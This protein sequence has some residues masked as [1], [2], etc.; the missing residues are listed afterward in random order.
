MKYSY[1]ELWR[2]FETAILDT[3]LDDTKLQFFNIIENKETYSVVEVTSGLNGDGDWENYLNDLK[4]LV[5][6]LKKQFEKVYLIKIIN[7]CLD[8]VFYAEIGVK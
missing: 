4:I 3:S 5:S 6:S 7:D 1:E 2:K 8:D